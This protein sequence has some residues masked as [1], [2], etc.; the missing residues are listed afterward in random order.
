MSYLFVSEQGASI[1]IRG[2][3]IEVKCKDEMLRSIPFETLETIQIFGHV[4][5]TTQCLAACLEKGI[6]LNYYSTTGRYYGRLV[7]PCHVN[8][9][10]QRMQA[11]IGEDREFCL[12][13]SKSI[14]RA[15]I[16]N[17]KVILRRYARWQ[18]KE[19]T[20]AIQGM[21]NMQKHVVDC[22]SI[23]QLM[24][25]EG[26]AAR[27]YFH[28]L[29]RL[30]IPEFA[31]DKRSRRPPRDEFN[32]MISLG[33]SILLNEIVGK[34]EGRG[35]NPY[36]G[37]MHSDKE[38]HPTLASDLMEEWRAVLVDSTT[39]SLVNGHE[40]RKSE[41]DR[42]ENGVYLSNSAFKTFIRKLDNKLR[43][44]SRYIEMEEFS[45]DFRHALDHQITSLV[46]AM[47]EKKPDIYQPV[48]IR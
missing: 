22:D 12:A 21:S 8:V 1:G 41:F 36:F 43:T 6:I 34:L 47:E 2:G 24:G 17:Q 3:R 30:I 38:K 45:T 4:N 10:R 27:I 23:P 15:K 28:T 16:Q 39:M 11:L 32:S 9:E 5:V 20:N 19:V 25:Y 37:M 40:I 13:F 18:D 7:S 14:I 44:D 42:D 48:V 31:F 29:G 26:A 46:K 33:Y 35:L